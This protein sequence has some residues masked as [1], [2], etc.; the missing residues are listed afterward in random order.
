MESQRPDTD[1][2]VQLQLEEALGHRRTVLVELL[3]SPL[4]RCDQDRAGDRF[5]ETPPTSRQGQATDRLGWC[6]HPPQPTRACVLE[7]LAGQNLGGTPPGLCPGTKSGGVPLGI[8]ETTRV[9]QPVRPRSLAT[10]RLG[11]SC[12]ASHPQETLPSYLRFLAPSRTLVN[13]R[14][15]KPRSPITFGTWRRLLRC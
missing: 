3:L 14:A 4:L 5:L 9:T 7:K 13:P 12:S 1:F 6:C 11:R 15:W 8:L 2:G 10:L